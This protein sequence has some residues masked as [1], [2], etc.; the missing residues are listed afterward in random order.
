MVGIKTCAGDGQRIV[1]QFARI[2]NGNSKP[3]TAL[4]RGREQLAAKRNRDHFQQIAD[5]QSITREFNTVGLD[6]EVITAGGALRVGTGG[7][8]HGFYDSLDVPGELLHFA[9][10]LA[11]YLDADRRADAGGEHV[12]PVLDWH[13][14]GI[15]DSRY[16]QGL[17]QFGDQLVDGYAVAPFTFRFQVDDRFGHLQRSRVGGGIGAP[18]LAE[19]GLHF[20]KCLDDF[21]LGLQ[22]LGG[23]GDG[24]R[25][26]S[27]RH[28][29]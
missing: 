3:F 27:D 28:V 26:Q 18:G 10:I 2:A 25:R 17:V 12:D 22:Q 6:I 14:P 4:Y 8:R 9:Q 7:S 1:P 23:F 19:H 11:E 20:G 15:A 5:R 21:V 16:L 24:Y 29:Q 13:G